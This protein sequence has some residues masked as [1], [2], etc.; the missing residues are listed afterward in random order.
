MQHITDRTWSNCQLTTNDNWNNERRSKS[1]STFF[2]QFTN[3]EVESCY[4]SAWMLRTRRCLLSQTLEKNITIVNEYWARWRKEFI[5]TLQ[6]QKLCGSKQR[7]IQKEDIA[8][9]KAGYNWNNWS[10]VRI[11]ETFPDKHGIVWTIKLILGDAV[12]AEQRE[13]VRPITKIVLLVEGNSPTESH[14]NTAK[15]PGNFGEARWNDNIII[16]L[17][18]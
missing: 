13:L 7:N 6:E 18:K 14:E 17:L 15:F 3:N 1:C 8:L 10:I 9:P 5:Q 4:P 2:F 12:G 11:I 16:G